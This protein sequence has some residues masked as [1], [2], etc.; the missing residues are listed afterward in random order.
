MS[1]D[2]IGGIIRTILAW[3]AG[4]IVAKGLLPSEVADAVTSGLVTIIVAV[5]SWKTNKPGTV[6]PPK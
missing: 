3:G 1:A 6:I 2:Q 4:Y 5:W